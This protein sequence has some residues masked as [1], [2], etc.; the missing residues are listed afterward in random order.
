MAK[1]TPVPTMTGAEALVE[2]LML[3]G[4]RDIFGLCGD[5]SLPFYDAL[6]RLEHGINHVLTR[7]ERS[8]AY[9]A[10]G[11]ARASGSVGVCE[12]PSGGGATYILPGVAEANESSVSL[13]C[14]TSDIA[15][16]SRG[17]F[18][19][20]ELDQ[21]ALFRPVTKSTQIVAR[22][23]RIPLAVCDAFRHATTGRP[24]AAHLGFPLDVQRELLPRTALAA[25]AANSRVPALRIAPDAHAIRA[26]ARLLAQARRPLFVIGGG[27]LVS[28]ACR[29]LKKVAETLG[30][31][32]CTTVSGK[33]SL[34]ETHPLAGGVIGSNGGTP[35]TRALVDSADVVVFVGCRAGS[36]TTE[37]WRHPQPGKPRIIHVD[38]DPRVFG[39]NYPTDVAV[40]ADAQL[41]L[42]A[43][44]LELGARA[45]W[46]KRAENAAFAVARAK[47]AKFEGFARLAASATRPLT[48]ERL[49]AD[50]RAVLDDDAVVVADP[51]TPCPYLAAYYETGRAGRHFISNRAHGALGYALA[52]AAGAHYA[53]PQAKVVAV[54]GDGSFGFTCGELETL[55]RLNVPI[56]MI[57]VSNAT[58][59][60]IKAGQRA[61]F[62]R[63]YFGVDFGRTDHAQVAAAFGVKSWR[64]EDP[65]KLRATLRAAARHHG[66]ALV[67]VVTQPLHLARAPVSEWIV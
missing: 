17:R 55:A 9:M 61:G 40:Q 13:L 35:P 2:M 11:Y 8:A 6:Y 32:V 38:I 49:V 63:R 42:T 23:E 57:V 62:D 51:G 20:T 44:L 16:A 12:G 46:R 60:W 28:S 22:A 48:P 65:A 58:Y 10:D 30:A 5:T 34:A 41:A 47:A 33:G 37:K 66:P 50:L 14:I 18:T 39:V 15:V 43:L 1:A 29:E 36:I 31:I 54:M 19:L 24:G 7:D 53:R 3:H 52:A 27:V 4:V 26:A 59:G 67:D 56:L 25:R 64:V 45:A 21:E